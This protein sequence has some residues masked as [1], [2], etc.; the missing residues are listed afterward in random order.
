MKTD[1]QLHKDVADELAYDPRVDDRQI[2]V[3]TSHGVVTLTGKAASY[4]EKRNADAIVKAVPGVRGVVNNIEVE[5]PGDHVRTDTD[6][7][8]AALSALAW[9]VA[10]PA[11]LL[12]TVEHGFLTLSG[13][14]AW[15]YQREAAEEAVRHL[16]GVI[17]VH[18]NIAIE[19]PIEAGEVERALE[20]RLEHTDADSGKIRVEA[21]DGKVT[22]RGTVHSEFE[23]EEASRAA[24]SVP[25]VRIVENL[26][27]VH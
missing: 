13:A 1:L 16:T 5:L 4:Y 17:S 21:D 22:L 10:L 12:V 25:G 15:P 11:N 6:I 26:L 8:E 27:A 18:N 14:V 23:L 19:P 3:A 7:A 9:H 2:G 24:W 20:R